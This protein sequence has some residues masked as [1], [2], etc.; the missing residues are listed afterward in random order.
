MFDLDLLS[1]KLRVLVLAP[2]TDDEF[3]CAG[4]ILRLVDA[5]AEV[6][7]YALS[8]C[9]ESVPAGLPRD[10]LVGECR[11]CTKSLGIL[12]ERVS[13]GE[14]KVRWFPRDRQEILE[15][16][17]KYNR[18]LKPQLIFVPSSYDTH[19]DHSTVGEECFRAFKYST[20]LGY[21]LPQNTISF[22]NSAFISLSEEQ[23][24]RKID[25]LACYKS[26]DFRS[27]ARDEFI[28]GLAKVRGVQCDTHYAE[29]FEVIRL[30][31]R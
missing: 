29:A 16:L 4:A 24:Q 14:F 31:I 3:G 18:E 20:I 7:Y 30:I 8:R 2:H 5:G 10:V 1:K 23:L 22:S 28:R 13:I 25:A 11:A 9:E 19:Q 15:S 12:P 17:V 21:E 26:Q 6:Y 27:Y